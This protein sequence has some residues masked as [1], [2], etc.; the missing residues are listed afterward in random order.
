MLRS[1]KI[2]KCRPSKNYRR[3]QKS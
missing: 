1:S 2:T 3:R